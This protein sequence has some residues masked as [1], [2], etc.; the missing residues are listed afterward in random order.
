M[1][2]HADSS[3][4][5]KLTKLV[6]ELRRRG[7]RITAQRLAIAKIVLENIKEH[8]SFMQILEK[9]RSTMPGI[10]PSTIY[11]NLQ[12]LEQLGLIRSF[13]VAGETRYDDVHDHINIVCIDSGKIFDVD[14]PEV[15]KIIKEQIEKKA[16]GVKVYNTIIYAECGSNGASEP[17]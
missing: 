2:T 17:G 13:D 3:V 11:N 5:E 10:S 12:L 15:V 1:S 7:L 4:D 14:N 8:P 16:G 6:T 9:I